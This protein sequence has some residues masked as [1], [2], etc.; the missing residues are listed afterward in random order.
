MPFMPSLA[1]LASCPWLKDA[2][3]GKVKVSVLLRL[4]GVHR[5]QCK[6][7]SSISSVCLSMCVVLHMHMKGKCSG[8]VQGACDVDVCDLAV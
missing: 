3:A 5:A 4:A 8:R 7:E 1:R 2:G 6:V